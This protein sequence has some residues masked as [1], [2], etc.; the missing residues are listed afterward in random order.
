MFLRRPGVGTAGL[1][2]A[3]PL[4]VFSRDFCCRVVAEEEYPE[5]RKPLLAGLS[6]AELICDSRC[7]GLVEYRAEL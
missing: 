5:V 7:P 6:T 4:T 1:R 2:L 3:G